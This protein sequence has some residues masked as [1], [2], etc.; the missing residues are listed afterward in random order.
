MQL[1]RLSVW[2]TLALAVLSLYSTNCTQV[3]EYERK[4]ISGFGCLLFMEMIDKPLTIMV[5]VFLNSKEKNN[6]QKQKIYITTLVHQVGLKIKNSGRKVIFS[7]NQGLL[8]HILAD[9]C[10]S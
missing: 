1:D 5:G 6:D 4:T 10:K 3:Q 9:M 8:K 7:H 2:L